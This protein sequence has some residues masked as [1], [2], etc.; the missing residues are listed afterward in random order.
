MKKILSIFATLALMAS[1]TPFAQ[2]KPIEKSPRSLDRQPTLA[3]MPDAVSIL[4]LLT[5][6]TESGG[7]GLDAAFESVQDD[8]NPPIITFLPPTLTIFP[9]PIFGVGVPGNIVSVSFDT[10]F[11][12]IVAAGAASAF[13]NISNVQ[14]D[15]LV[16]FFDIV[17]IQFPTGE[18]EAGIGF[19]AA[20][21]F[22]GFYDPFIF[23]VCPC[24]GLDVVVTD[25]AGNVSNGVAPVIVVSF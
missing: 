17:Q 13:G 9:P 1:Q 22:V 4:N 3:P 21:R 18:I 2:A 8:T 7:S 20:A 11:P 12:F 14:V 10:E 23:P 19:F 25:F 15:E 24:G 16:T 6:S 5:M